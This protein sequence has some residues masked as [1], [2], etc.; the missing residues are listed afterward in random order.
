[1]KEAEFI[2]DCNIVHEDLVSDTKIAMGEKK[3]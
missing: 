3:I 2:C 1:M